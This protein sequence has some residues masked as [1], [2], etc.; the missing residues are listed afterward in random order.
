MSNTPRDF[1]EFHSRMMR[2]IINEHLYV[3]FT[4][5]EVPP[6]ASTNRNGK[7]TLYIPKKYV[8]SVIGESDTMHWNGEESPQVLPTP[9]NKCIKPRPEY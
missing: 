1:A 9:K 8:D 4:T 5:K 6:V 2:N 3:T 7:V